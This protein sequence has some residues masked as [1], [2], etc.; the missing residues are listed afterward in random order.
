MGGERQER[1]RVDHQ[2]RCTR[3]FAT[4]TKRVVGVAGRARAAARRRRK[5]TTRED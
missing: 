2:A 3:Y 4:G 5:R 1:R